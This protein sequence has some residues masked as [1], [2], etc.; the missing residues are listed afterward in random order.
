MRLGDFRL[1]IFGSILY[2][3][4]RNGDSDRRGWTRVCLEFRWISWTLVPYCSRCLPCCPLSQRHPPSDPTTYLN[5]HLRHRT[6]APPTSRALRPDGDCWRVP[7]PLTSSFGT[8]AGSMHRDGTR[9]SC[10]VRPR[11]C[12]GGVQATCRTQPRMAHVLLRQLSVKQSIGSIEEGEP[13]DKRRL[14]P[15]RMGASWCSVLAAC[16]P[17]HA[18]RPLGCGKPTRRVVNSKGTMSQLPGT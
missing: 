1:C 5:F 11:C 8:A 14:L 3:E 12:D 10:H 15:E 9:I 4:T 18:R 16:R 2:L 13:S 6:E 7:G 17:P